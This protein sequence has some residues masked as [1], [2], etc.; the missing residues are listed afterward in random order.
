MRLRLLILLICLMALAWGEA[1]AL[2]QDVQ[3]VEN[4]LKVFPVRKLRR[5]AIGDPTIADVTVLSDRELM[6]VAKKSGA[7][8][9]IIWEESGQRS[10][11][12]HV[13]KKD[14]EK[15]AQRIREL[16]VSSDVRGV[17]VK[18]EQDNVYVIGEVLNQ[19]QADKVED[20][21]KP[22]KDTANLVR[23]KERQP[24]VEI[25]VNVLE[26]SIDDLKR[27]GMDWSNSLPLRY[28]EPSTTGGDIPKLWKVFSWD[29][30]TIDARLNFLI[31]QNK[32]RTLAN[33]KLICLSGKEASFL[34]GGEVPY[35]T[36]R[37]EGKTS[38]E[39]KEYGVNLK[40][41]P[42]V[43][44]KNEIK[45]EITAEVSNL[46]WGNAVS[47]AGF[48]IPAMTKR[49]VQTELFLDEE[50][51]A[52]FAGLIKNADSR[53]IERVPWLSKVPILGEL[54]KST[55]FRDERTE[56]VI[57]ITPRIIGEK[58]TPDYISSEMLKHE[59]LLAVQRA[60]PAY[61][62]ESSPLTYYS[63]MIEDIIAH[64]VVY[65]GQA[66]QAKLEGIVKIDLCLLFN[67]QLK[68]AKIKESS[69]FSALDQAALAA[70]QEQAPYPSFPSQ[71]SQKELWLTVP[72]VFKSYLK[73]E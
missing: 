60:F 71:V 58:A 57:S 16:L 35:V 53:N 52:F 29:R 43:N 20:V 2:V 23:I 73:N 37:E 59:R 26:V 66:H 47:H 9:L 3:L 39:W 31:E 44:A 46:D 56:L 32:A 4:E 65:P 6:L 55:D 63:H 18:K 49:K 24:L 50:D 7:T 27:L 12:I 5:V 22:F 42:L 45:T 64:N 17:R 67:G 8:S 13:I 72:V 51:T 15:V 48:T 1:S 69:G 36:E 30:T 34:V 62:E 40:I 21:L 68:E 28:S 54:F 70:V 41:K 11:N 19:R 38:V 33:P 10:F 25:D 61:S 14:L